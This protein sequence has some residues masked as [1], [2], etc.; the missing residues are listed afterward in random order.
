MN[1]NKS[2]TFQIIVFIK[3]NLYKDNTGIILKINTVFFQKF[4]NMAELLSGSDSK[5]QRF[6]MHRGNNFKLLKIIKSE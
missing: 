3:T 2:Y 4:A 5:Y 6:E 1:N